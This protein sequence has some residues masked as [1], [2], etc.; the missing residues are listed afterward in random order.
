VRRP[1]VPYERLKPLPVTDDD[2]LTPRASCR[3]EW[4]LTIMW[5]IESERLNAALSMAR[6]IAR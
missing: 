1:G 5:Y 6:V 3:R 2:D 4:I